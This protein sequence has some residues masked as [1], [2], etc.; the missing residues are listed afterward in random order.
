MFLTLRGNITTINTIYSQDTDLKK[1]NKAVVLGETDEVPTKVLIDAGSDMNAI[2]RSFY[3]KIA[4]NHKIF[5]KNKVYFKLASNQI[6]STNRVVYLN[7]KFIDLEIR[8][9]FWLLDD[10]KEFMKNRL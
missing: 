9:M 2:T 8:T 10:Y 7:L 4:N 1:V 6:V 3:N 5:F